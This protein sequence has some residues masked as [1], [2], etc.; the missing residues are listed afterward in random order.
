MRQGW[1]A[2]AAD[3]A[4][5]RGPVVTS[6]RTSTRAQQRAELKASQRGEDSDGVLRDA[7]SSPV[8]SGLI[9]AGIAVLVLGGAIA[10][11]FGIC[12]LYTSRCV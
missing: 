6:V 3:L 12:L 1:V 8:K 7:P 4:R 5:V 9:G 10:A 2:P 11:A